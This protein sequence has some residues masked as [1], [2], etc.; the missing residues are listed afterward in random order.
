[1]TT[2]PI[3]KEKSLPQSPSP[4]STSTPKE[5]RIEKVWVFEKKGVFSIVRRQ[6][7]NQ[8]FFVK[9]A[10]K[11]EPVKAVIVFEEWGESG[12]D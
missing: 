1:M 8:L 11:I 10:M 5:K 9:N 2:Q 4:N 3:E 12:N 7:R 6:H